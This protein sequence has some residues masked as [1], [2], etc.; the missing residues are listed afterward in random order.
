MGKRILTRRRGAAKPRLT[1]PSHKHK[2]DVRYPVN[3]EGTG[4][5]IGLVHAPGRTAVLCKVLF[6]DGAETQQIA[7]EG[8]H[9]GQ[10]IVFTKTTQ[11][12]PGNVTIVSKIPEGTPIFNVEARPN[13]GG[14]FCRSAGN[15]AEIVSHDGKKTVIRLPSGKFRNFHPQCRATIGL[16]AGGG[17]GDKPF[18]KAGKKHHLMKTKAQRWPRVRGVAMNP[19]DHPHG[20]GAHN[21]TPGKTSVA[22]GTPPGRKV[23]KIAPS[24][25][26]KR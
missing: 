25:T 17:R 11:I 14:T 16:A 8:C 2:G 20:G 3:F 26:G 9:V 18:L 12:K 23:G 15:A 6:E 4:K 10:E 13:D 24:R 5:V 1:S 19:V 21:Y 7:A 22:R